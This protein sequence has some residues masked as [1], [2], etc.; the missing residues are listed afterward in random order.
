MSDSLGLTFLTGAHER[1][2]LDPRRGKG[3]L[4]VTNAPR[5]VY[6]AETGLTVLEVSPVHA[7]EDFE[8]AGVD[9]ARVVPGSMDGGHDLASISRAVERGVVVVGGAGLTLE[10]DERA[11]GIGVLACSAR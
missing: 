10:Q 4:K 3:K 7:N 9:K 5:V 11:F 6:S 1:H 8:N 2:V